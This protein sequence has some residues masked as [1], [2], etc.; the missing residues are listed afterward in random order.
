MQ[1]QPKKPRKIL[2][3]IRI[4]TEKKTEGIILMLYKTTEIP[5][6]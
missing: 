6:L 1:W 5:L 2:D 3:I 4:E